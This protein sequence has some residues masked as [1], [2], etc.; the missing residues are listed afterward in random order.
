MTQ[1]AIFYELACSSEARIKDLRWFT[2]YWTNSLALLSSHLVLHGI[3]Y[4]TYTRELYCTEGIL[5]IKS[6]LRSIHVTS[7]IFPYT[8]T[9]LIPL[10][11]CFAL[12]QALGTATGAYCGSFVISFLSPPHFQLLLIPFIKFCDC[13]LMFW[14]L[15]TDERLLF[16]SVDRL[17]LTALDVG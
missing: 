2:S 1:P 12:S 17:L 9:A 11:Q 13:N 6:R 14:L 7:I 10:P 4:H 15:Y 8:F 16:V 3:Y 5:Y